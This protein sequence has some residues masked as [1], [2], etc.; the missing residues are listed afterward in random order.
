MSDTDECRIPGVVMESGFRYRPA[1]TVPEGRLSTDALR[2][3]LA[4]MD[5]VDEARLRAAR[6]IR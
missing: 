2:R 4:K 6:E 5:S 1:R 3:V